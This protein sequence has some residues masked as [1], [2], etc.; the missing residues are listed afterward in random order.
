MLMKSV[1]W[2][3]RGRPLAGVLG[4][5]GIGL[6]LGSWV[7][8]SAYGYTK[9]SSPNAAIG[10]LYPLNIHGYIVY[11]NSREQYLFYGLQVV[12]ALFFV[13]GIIVD[14]ISSRRDGASLPR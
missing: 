11:L 14:V 1:R 8:G 2:R 3:I 13:T 6:G 5:I 9:P 7:L 10:R 12:A 4:A